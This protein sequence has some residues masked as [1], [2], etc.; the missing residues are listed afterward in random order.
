MTTSSVFFFTDLIVNSRF[1]YCNTK[2]IWLGKSRSV[3]L[4]VEALSSL[5]HLNILLP[6]ISYSILFLIFLFASFLPFPHHSFS[7]FF[8]LLKL[9]Y[10]NQRLITYN[11]VVVFCHT[12]IWISLGFTCILLLLFKASYC[13]ILIGEHIFSF[14]QTVWGHTSSQIQKFPLLWKYYYKQ[15]Y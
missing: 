6:F 10:F 4:I 5:W 11:N 1:P 3:P 13:Y 8:F 15:L 2:L 12:L 9:I 7:P 14:A